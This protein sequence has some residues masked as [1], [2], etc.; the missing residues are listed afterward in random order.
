MSKEEFEC[1]VYLKKPIEVIEPKKIICK[2][3][4]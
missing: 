2:D 4:L 3:F 1:R